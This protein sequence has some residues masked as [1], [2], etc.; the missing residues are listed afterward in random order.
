M[1]A[2]SD[3]AGHYAITSHSART[4]VQYADGP[5]VLERRVVATVDSRGSSLGDHVYY[6]SPA[7]WQVSASVNLPGAAGRT[8]YIGL[9]GFDSRCCAYGVA[10]AVLTEMKFPDA[11]RRITLEYPEGYTQGR[12]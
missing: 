11:Q 6:R 8:N 7:F 4:L 1:Y 2:P 12:S 3:S 9:N 10:L 5:H